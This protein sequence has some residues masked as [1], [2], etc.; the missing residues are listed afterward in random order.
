MGYFVVEPAVKYAVADDYRSF[1]RSYWLDIVLLLPFFKMLK[2]VGT[3]GKLLKSLRVLPYL[4]KAVELPK[5]LRQM[6]SALVRAIAGA[7]EDSATDA[8][9]GDPEEPER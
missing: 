3:V 9:S 5:M 1:L 4:R 8:G 7:R 6:R 2:L